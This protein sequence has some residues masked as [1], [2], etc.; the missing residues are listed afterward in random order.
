MFLAILSNIIWA[1]WTIYW[2]RSLWYWVWWIV[3]DLLWYP[4]RL[5]LVLFL[6]F[7]SV[8]YSILD[9]KFFSIIIFCCIF[10]LIN[11][12]IYQNICRESKMSS[13]L[14]FNNLS[15]VFS[16]IF[17]VLF[18][19]DW[20]IYSLIIC[21]AIIA[22][23]L[24]SQIDL[25]NY[26]LPKNILKILFMEITS[27]FMILASW[28]AIKEYWEFEYLSFY[29]LFW[30]IL[31][32]TTAL[33]LWEFKTLIWQKS[34]FWKN[35][36][37]SSIIFSIAFVLNLFVIWELWISMWVLLSFIFP[38]FVI[39]LWITMLWEEPSKKDI[40]LNIIITSL[41]WIAYIIK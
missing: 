24:L 2:K 31:L 5:L 16:I 6:L 35:K 20:T 27:S 9:L 38:A 25:K 39:V 3:I 36:I 23:L 17:A 12:Q 32:T 28:Y 34:W 26:K 41:V 18:L 29:V 13:I 7:Y 33:Y 21:I 10:A 8:D 15:K 30:V 22:I 11:T 14:P 40:I 1:I 19:S 4:P 37:I